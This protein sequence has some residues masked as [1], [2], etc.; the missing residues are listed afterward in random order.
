MGSST[1]K[2]RI[3]VV[4][5]PDRPP[6]KD[7]TGCVRYMD[8]KRHTAY[9]CIR[10]ACSWAMGDTG[11][12]QGTSSGPGAC[13]PSLAMTR[14]QSG[15][16]L[17]V[18]CSS[19]PAARPED[20]G[21]TER[22]KRARASSG[23]VDHFSTTSMQSKQRATSTHQIVAC[24]GHP[25]PSKCPFSGIRWNG[26]QVV[27]ERQR[28]RCK[29]AQQGARGRRGRSLGVQLN[30]A[31]ALHRVRKCSGPCEPYRPQKV[32]EQ[33]VG[34]CRTLFHHP[35]LARDAQGASRDCPSHHGWFLCIP[36]PRMHWQNCVRLCILSKHGGPRP[37]RSCHQ[38]R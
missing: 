35:V 10:H 17:I 6:T 38:R 26:R 33:T 2:Q 22:I 12:R 27:H 16:Q 30:P 15:F 24:G 9:G 11:T 8:S 20:P 19:R 1:K 7:R 5:T 31:E 28:E 21:A 36:D 18:P 37:P 4:D 29:R 3:E 32:D 34:A 23:S 14:E 25:R 13:Q